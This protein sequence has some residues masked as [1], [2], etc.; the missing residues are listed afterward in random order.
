M[1]V[2]TTKNTH[3]PFTK[4]DQEERLQALPLKFLALTPKVGNRA[5]T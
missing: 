3:D 4:L 2:R 1:V 5:F